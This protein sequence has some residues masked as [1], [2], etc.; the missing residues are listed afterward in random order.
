[1]TPS[2]LQLAPPDTHHCFCLNPNCNSPENPADALACQKCGSLLRLVGRYRAIKLIGASPRTRTFLAVDNSSP[3]S[4]PGVMKQFSLQ[5]TPLSSTRAVPETPAEMASALTANSEFFRQQA[6]CLEKLGPH[7]QLPAL[8]A[9]F[10]RNEQQYF[11]REFVSGR[12]LA[13][14][15]AQEGA[16]DEIKIRQLLADL[17]P[18]LHL[19]HSH[20]LIH[21]H[22]KP[23]N[24]IRRSSDEK[25]AL[26]DFAAGAASPYTA[27][28]Q[29]TGRATFASDIYSLGVTCI[30]LITQIPPSDLSDTRTGTWVWRHYLRGPVS[31]KLGKILDRMLRPNTKQRYPSAPALLR[32][33]TASH[34]PLAQN[35]WLPGGALLLLGLAAAAGALRLPPTGTPYSTNLLQLFGQ[36]RS[37][38]SSNGTPNAQ[39]LPPAGLFALFDGEIKVFPL[40]R[41]QVQAQISGNLSRV[42]VRQTFA[43]PYEKPLAAIYKFPLLGEAAVDEMEIRT[44]S[45]TVRGS[46]KRRDAK[47][48]NPAGSQTKQAEKMAAMLEQKDDS[49]FTQLVSDIK[50]GEKIEVTI[51]YTG[52]LKFQGGDFEF[53][54]P[55]AVGA[56]YIPGSSLP[57]T[58][59]AAAR[60][61]GVSAAV[62]AKQTGSQQGIDVTVALNAGVPAVEVSSPTHELDVQ[63]TG[64]T[65]RVKLANSNEILNRDLILRYRAAGDSTQVTALTQSGERGG[66]FAAYL[67]P[68]SAYKPEEII[69]KDVVFLIDT[70]GSQAGQPIRQSQELMRLFISGLNSKDTFNIIDFAIPATRLSEE[71]VPNT[72]S[73]RLRAIAYINR[74]NATGGTKLTNGIEKVL[75]LPPAP[76]GRLRCIVLLSQGDIGDS[77]TIIAEVQKK[78]KSGN[79]LYSFGVGREVNRFLMTRLAEVGGGTATFLSPD[80]P[81]QP[82]AEK[83]FRQINNPA[84]T[85]I[86]VSWIGSGE[87]PEIYPLKAPDLFANQPLVLFGRKGDRQSGQLRIQGML[88]GGKRYDK[89]LN[90]NFDGEKGNYAVAQMWGRAR[91]EYL[92]NQVYVGAPAERIW[93]AIDTALAYRLLS[94]YTAFVAVTQD[95][96]VDANNPQ[97]K[98]GVPVETPERVSD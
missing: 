88:A 50:P 89:I 68:A 26:V 5:N 76:P 46:I 97:E 9:H 2:N 25:L 48:A 63:R 51:R 77:Q 17:L 20:Q 35:I 65:V 49:V 3:G 43:N 6:T 83:F 34:T 57:S 75:N 78:L 96:R 67:I 52:T 58:E 13:D 87:A 60:S 30:H 90:V 36:R 56:G 33:L 40:Q 62:G 70:S 79:R 32:D 38:G 98:V 22:I 53:V 41:A 24:I 93:D 64:S 55:F 39:Q 28:E 69:P 86:E 11:V 1:M 84:L 29:L 4:P 42:T 18:V 73:N 12:N 80:E 74:L 7:P 54:L 15:L 47:Q 82:V 45:R 95:L 14:E 81:A 92:M 19:A 44:G 71:P 66:H 61:A 31:E 10:Q 59:G 21:R 91:F 37:Y 16:F 72:L 85:N 27:P 94:R 23:E 8:L